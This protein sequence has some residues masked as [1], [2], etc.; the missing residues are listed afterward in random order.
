MHLALGSHFINAGTYVGLPLIGSAPDLG[1]FEYNPICSVSSN[2]SARPELQLFQNYPNPFNPSTTIV[3][4]V[5]KPGM[6]SLTLYDVLGRDVVTLV[7]EVKPAGI[8]TAVWNAGGMPSG[9]YFSRLTSHG[10]Q[11]IRKMILMK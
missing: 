6:V 9:M 7:N 1:C 2:A 4:Q 10:E 11:M 5:A 3:Y 8:Y